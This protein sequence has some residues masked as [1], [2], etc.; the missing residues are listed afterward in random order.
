MNEATINR[1]PTGRIKR[2]APLLLWLA[3]ITYSSS[4]QMSASNTSWI[5]AA[6][7]RWFSPDVSNA[8][9]N[10]LTFLVRK[11]AH[12]A[13]YAVLAV[14]AAR[15]C[16]TSTHG[17]IHRHWF[18]LAFALVALCAL[19]DELHQSFVASRTGSMY[20]S[21]LDMTGGLTALTAL[22]I[23]RRQWRQ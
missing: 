16:L 9:L 19:S 6:V 7:A 8:A 23:W 5:I 14:L 1:A 13:E 3:F 10:Q 15:V 21:L 22:K 2:Y 12:F 17:L 20:D 4:G 11:T 18:A